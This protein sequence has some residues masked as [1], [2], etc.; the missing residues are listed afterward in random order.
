MEAPSKHKFIGQ[1]PWLYF[2]TIEDLNLVRAFVIFRPLNK[3]SS[4]WASLKALF[5]RSISYIFREFTWRGIFNHS[6]IGSR[7]AALLM[8]NR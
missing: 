8:A 4:D 3:F 6:H 1:K 2:N 7:F 5:F